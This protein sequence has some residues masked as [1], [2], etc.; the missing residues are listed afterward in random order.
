MCCVLFS[1][2]DSYSLLYQTLSFQHK[3]KP[4][5]FFFFQVKNQKQNS[6]LAY[7]TIQ[8]WWSYQTKL[9][10]TAERYYVVTS[11]HRPPKLA[12]IPPL[13]FIKHI[14][15]LFEATFLP[16][17]SFLHGH[18]HS[19][20]SSLSYLKL[21]SVPVIPLSALMCAHVSCITNWDLASYTNL[22]SLLHIS[23]SSLVFCATSIL[24]CLQD[25]T[26]TPKWFR[27][28]PKNDFIRRAL[29]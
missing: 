18:C 10:L 28:H 27:H 23:F 7:S 22:T 25:F 21:F 15:Y 6:V 20:L 13:T 1:D 2:T 11:S 29:Y 4:K 14:F 17:N 24:C 12:P 16:L 9:P 26:E 5:S 8:I 19:F 3:M